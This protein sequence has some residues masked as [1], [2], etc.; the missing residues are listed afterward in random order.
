MSVS[1]SVIFNGYQSFLAS[2]L[3]NN[4]G[5]IYT[6]L[7]GTNTPATTYT[8]NIGNIANANPIPLSAGGTPP[9]EIWLT[10]GVAYKMVVFDSTLSP[11]PNGS[12][13]NITGAGSN[14][15][16]FILSLESSIG[17]TLMG[18]IQSG[19]G[20]ILRTVQDKLR[21]Q[22]VTPFDFMTTAQIADVQNNVGSI[23]MTTYIQAALNRTG[24]VMIP[25]GTWLFDSVNIPANTHMKTAGF[26]TIFKQAPQASVAIRGLIFTGSNSSIGDLV[27]Q[28]NIAT[29]TDEQNH[30]VFIQAS[31]V[32]LTNI[33][34]GNIRG[35]NVRGDVLYIGANTGFA[36]RQIKA[37]EIYGDN[38]LRNC[39]SITGC[40]GVNID[41][42]VG[43]RTGY[44]ALDIEPEP[45]NTT[46]INIW[47]GYVRGRT[48][49]LNASS[50]AS[51]IDAVTIDEMDLDLT[52]TTCTPAYAGGAGLADCLSLRNTKS[53]YIGHAKL[54]GAN[55]GGVFVTTG[56]G[57]LGAEAVHFGHIDVDTCAITDLVY[58]SFM[59][60]NGSP[61]MVD[62]LKA[63]VTGA[64]SIALTP[65]GGFI[66][67]AKIDV[68]ATG[69]FLRNATGMAVKG[70]TQT[71][72]GGAG[73]V[74]MSSGGGNAIERCTI[75]GSNLASFT[76]PCTFD[77]VTA[78]VTTIFNGANDIH[79]IRQS[80]I[81]GV[82]YYGVGSANAAATSGYLTP[83]RQG[84][85]YFWIEQAT[86]KMRTKNSAPANDADGTVVGTQ[87]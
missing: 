61:L 58:A 40:D 87:V 18:F 3:P 37:G 12:F 10:D 38:I 16:A 31:T 71:G 36:A 24:D 29:D 75:T 48:A 5:F 70:V 57:E 34:V 74:F 22:S 84:V 19:I 41:G 23:N 51:Y 6:Y 2:G 21:E 69:F 11:V 43:D 64:R 42:I 86:G 59:V 20:A 8:T 14:L 1:L 81:N 32:D 54:R 39:V 47:V 60:M 85:Y 72:G 67:Y 25:A 82:N 4:G 52:R 77:L 49:G 68:A 30:A 83:F 76:T 35:Y 50:A 17:S 26:A 15:A 63:T 79:Q 27:F 45:Y 28:G 7:A 56:G 73:G 78:T 55:R 33:T 65:T 9:N 13:D 80:V 62:S 66:N 53:A 46:S 44:M